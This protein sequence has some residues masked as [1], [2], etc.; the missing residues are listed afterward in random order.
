MT[1]ARI[2]LAVELIDEDG[3]GVVVTR[4]D[5]IDQSTDRVTHIRQ[6]GTNAGYVSL[7]ELEQFAR[8]LLEFVEHERHEL[9]PREPAE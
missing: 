4:R 1:G 8:H 2:V 7:D 9:N 3:D 5:D 6:T